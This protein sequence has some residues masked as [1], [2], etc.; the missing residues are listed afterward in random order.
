MRG[1]A[2]IF[3]FIPVKPNTDYEFT[4]QYRAEELDTASGPRFSITDPY[5]DAFIRP[6]R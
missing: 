3:Q 6:Y 4:A 2:G 5:S 1:D